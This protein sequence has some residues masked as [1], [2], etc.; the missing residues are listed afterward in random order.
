MR[1]F[2]RLD[3]DLRSEIRE[4]VEIETRQ[5]LERGMSPEAA[6]HAAERSF[7]NPGVVREHVREA[8]PMYWLETIAQDVRFA[9]RQLCRMPVVSCAVMLTLTFGVGLNSAAFTVIERDLFY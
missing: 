9:T 4:H 5:K 6:R 2:G 7:G 3:A 1:W 8:R